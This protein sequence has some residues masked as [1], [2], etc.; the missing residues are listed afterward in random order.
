MKKLAFLILLGITS[1]SQAQTESDGIRMSKGAFCGGLTYTYS[2]WS[3]YWEGTFRRDNDNIGRVTTSAFSIMG[4][5]GLLDH[6][7]VVFSLP[8]IATHSSA[9][10]LMGQHGIQ[11]FSLFLKWL[12]YM[13]PGD[14]SNFQIYGVMGGSTP[15]NSYAADF[16]P[17]SIGLK[18]SSVNARLIGDYQVRHFFITASGNFIYRFNIRIDRTA[19]FTDRMIYSNEVFMPNVFSSE[20]GTGFRNGDLI[21]EGVIDTWNTLGGFDIRKNDMPFP[22]NRMNMIRT[23]VNLKIP[24]E[25]I[26]GL[27]FV[28]NSFYTIRG[29]NVGQALSGTLGVFYIFN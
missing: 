28:A 26:G 5:W 23:G 7:N 18:S 16:M 25:K 27:S 9:G 10:T 2:S 22:S 21:F 4:A 17:M 24:V 20:L 29:R 13:R 12:A 6:L 3:N 19:Y 15:L 14:I 11:D 1:V 8:Y